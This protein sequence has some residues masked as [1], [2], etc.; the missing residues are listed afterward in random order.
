MERSERESLKLEPLGPLEPQCDVQ[1]V[2]LRRH[3][4]LRRDKVQNKQTQGTHESSVGVL[5][6]FYMLQ[7]CVHIKHVVVLVALLSCHHFTC[8]QLFPHIHFSPVCEFL[9][10]FVD[11]HT[12]K[13][14]LL[15]CCLY[16]PSVTVDRRQL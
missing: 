15:R 11:C 13:T 9:A 14:G 8:C 1:R 2:R 10:Y 3:Q 7:V 16:T 6:R 4:Q 12:A 5:V